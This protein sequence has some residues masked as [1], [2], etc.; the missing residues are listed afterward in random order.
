MLKLMRD[1]APVMM[2][3]IIAAFVG[4][5]FFSW[6]RGSSIGKHNRSVAIVNGKEIPIQSF[7]RGVESQREAYRKQKNADLTP[8][9]NRMVP[10]QILEN[11][12]SRILL[13]DVFKK[14]E[15]SGSVNEIFDY[16]AKNPPPAF[17]QSESF[18]TETG[19]FDT[20]R[21]VQYLSTPESF[22][23][24]GMLNLEDYTANMIV[25]MEK[26]RK[27][28]EMGN[29]P[30]TSEIEYEYHLMK[31][32]ALFEYAKVNKSSFTPSEKELS[33]DALKK[34]YSENIDSFETS[35]QRDLYYLKV[36]K[37]ATKADI[38]VYLSE[39]KDIK[40]RILAKESTFDEEARAESDDDGSA[41]NGGN[42]GWFTKGKMVK[43][44]DDVVFSMKPGEISDPVK[45]QF[46]YHVITVD[47]ISG[48]SVKARHILR[49]IEPSSETLDSLEEFL[50]GI[51]EK[52]AVDGF[53]KVIESTD[54][55]ELKST[56]IFP[57]DGD[58]PTIGYVSGAIRYAF[59]NSK[60]KGKI[61]DVLENRE[62]YYI[63]AV[64]SKIEKGT[65]PFKYAKERSKELLSKSLMESKAVAYLEN[66]KASVS[67]G[68]IATL[69]EGD[70][71][72][73]SGVTDTVTQKQYINSDITYQGKAIS[74]AF[75]SPVNK[76]SKVINDNGAV[77]IVKPLFQEVATVKMDSPEV[78]R[79]KDNLISAA[80]KSAYQEWYLAYK[81][82]AKISDNLHK[83][84]E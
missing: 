21:Y 80:K 59:D 76:V 48:D 65:L 47:S 43:E 39:L 5:I 74:L 4:T 67:D 72:V 75:S 36:E 10:K 40:K 49:I 1:I 45:T 32:R 34:Y 68:S 54:G 71:L 78:M 16:L 46:G 82:G 50:D 33:G 58:I 24:R 17:L 56:G 61:S 27:L 2:W 8:A 53:K 73:I 11:E 18:R 37:K 9:E 83:F 7:S 12:I 79:I 84:Y 15:L 14:M 31:D 6:G 44:F 26:L 23:D 13:K 42:L 3:F 77:Y 38:D 69:S 57:Q 63:F 52:M 35:A 28:I 66:I 81:S 51:H 62:A 20:S 70:S 22:N 29:V 60:D 64:K 55:V 19:A 41:I 30:S 25:P